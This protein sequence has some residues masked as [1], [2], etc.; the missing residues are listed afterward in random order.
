M[1]KIVPEE[2]LPERLSLLE[3]VQACYPSQVQDVHDS[4]NRGLSVLIEC[5]KTLNNFLYQILRRQLRDN[6]NFVMIDGRATEQPAGGLG[7]ST[8]V[9][10]ILQRITETVRNHEGDDD[11]TTVLVLPHLDLLVSGNGTLVTSEAKEAIAIM[12]EN[13]NIHWIGFKDPSF[14][15]PKTITQLYSTK[16]EFLGI[17]RDRLRFLVT[18]RESRKFRQEKGLD[19]YKLYKQVSGTNPIRLRSLLNSLS[20]MED[21]PSDS[22]E[23]WRAIR[24]GTV[25]GDVELPTTTFDDIGGYEKVKKKFNEEIIEFIKRCD[26]EEDIDAIQ[27]MET[28]IPKGILLAGPPGTGKT[29]FAKA[30][31]NELGASVHIV[32]GPEL[33]SRWVGE[34][35][36]NLRRVFN[37]ARQSAPSII[38][39]DE[40]DSFAGRRDSFSSSGVDHSMVN[41][42]LTEMDG[43][44][45]NEMVFVVGT[46]NFVESIDP[47]L[48]RPGRFEF[49]L[50]IPF[51]EDEDREA[52]LEIYNKKFK[53]DMSK[54]AI[55]SAVIASGYPLPNGGRW[56]GDH[57][58]ALCRQIARNR[59]RLAKKGKTSPKDVETA[60]KVSQEIIE[61][62]KDEKH[63]VATHECGHAIVA[64]EMKNM[65]P[66]KRISIQGDISGALGF[67]EHG[68]S[69]NK[70]IITHIELF[71]SICVLF[72]GPLAEE[73]HIGKK[74]VGSSHDL[75]MAN[76]RAR[77]LVENFGYSE[78]SSVVAQSEKISEETRTRIDNQVCAIMREAEL[79]ARKILEE[80]KDELKVLRKEL[81]KKE[82]IDCRKSSK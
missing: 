58:Q 40:L 24:M 25:E 78:L 54:K 32:N 49:H 82:S 28:L 61:L 64:M 46:T 48:L 57:L 2:E 51:P 59:L 56:S 69:N 50:T 38:V 9:G 73:I 13:P 70:N 27:Q 68:E 33:K 41:Q 52:I 35:E 19:I 75:H 4:L 5:E 15:L 16:I 10:A 34:S 66:I 12:H 17:P 62:N 30:L 65:P 22:R 42:L 60:R 77:A 18:Q 53:L 29:L 43:F 45:D 80:K 26:D 14:S 37:E 21:Y 11:K 55:E 36:E 79:R 67:V 39:F 63:I 23:V 81:L 8:I 7:P 74:S 31:A 20:N 3:T 72:G 71:E 6:F 1:S 47:A 44:Q 76:K